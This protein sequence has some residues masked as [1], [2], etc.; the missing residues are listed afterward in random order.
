MTKEKA[1]HIPVMLNEVIQCLNL[2]P[3]DVVVDATVG[4][5]GH[6]ERILEEILPGGKLI[7][8]DRDRN[9]LELAEKRL[10]RFKGHFYLFHENFINLDKVLSSLNIKKV[11]AV[12]F[13]L[14]ISSYQLENRRGFSFKE[15][16]FLDMRLDTDESLTAYDIVNYYSLEEL[17]AIIK[18]YGEERYHRKIAEE[19]VKARRFQSI[20][21]TTELKD[22]ILRAVPYSYLKQKIH[23]ATRTFQALR[24]A[25]NGELENLEKAL[26][27]TVELLLPE[28][29]LVVISF[30]SLEDRI[31]KRKFRYFSKENKV[32]IITS[33]PLRPTDFEI[34]INPRAR[35]AKLRC[36]QRRNN[37]KNN[38]LLK[39]F[40][41]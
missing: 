6:G 7:G 5:G 11:D 27:R 33:K 41:L 17:S 39:I 9:S 4:L 23:P 21:T 2:K 12:L 14:G 34:Q 10:S 38:I 3:G 30:H 28:G 26:D 25:V 1:E 31:V 8:V 19:I 36:V 24:I 35:S 40:L 37:H 18:N 29:R 20:E 16:A 22:I 13:D 15:D 32:E